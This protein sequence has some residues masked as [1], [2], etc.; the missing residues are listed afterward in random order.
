MVE[1]D[2]EGAIHERLDLTYGVPLPP[3]DESWLWPVAP[4]GEAERDREYVH[5]VC[6]WRRLGA[7]P[8]LP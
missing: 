4:F 7:R 1:R 5:R 3:E 6:A 8:L 2:R